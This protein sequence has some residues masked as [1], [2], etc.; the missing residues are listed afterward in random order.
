M[1]ARAI[2]TGVV[3]FAGLALPVKL[4]TAVDDRPLSFRLLSAR[5]GE[6]VRQRMVDPESN[7]VVAT[8][9]QRMAFEIEPGRFVVLDE[10][11]RQSARPQPSRSIEI[12]RFLPR[13]QIDHR[14]YERPYYLGPNHGAEDDYFALAAAL[15]QKGEAGVARWVMRSKAYSGSLHEREGYLMLVTLHPAEEVVRAGQLEAPSSE[16]LSEREVSLAQQIV[17]AYRGELEL[18]KYRDEYRHAVEQL[19]ATKA[20]GAKVEIRAVRK[21][22]TSRSL[23]DALEASLAQTDSSRRKRRGS[24][25]A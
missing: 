9:D 1:A 13:D 7:Q 2:W 10:E 20:K 17:E 19:I 18:D 14:W 15:G 22:R 5:T 8:E 3:Q 4:Y 21:K 11:E 23:V 12:V 6:G 24:G 25:H 16:P